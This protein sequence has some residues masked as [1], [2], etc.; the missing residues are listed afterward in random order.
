MTKGTKTTEGTEFAESFC[1]KDG[2]GRIGEG[3]AFFVETLQD[4]HV[5]VVLIVLQGVKVRRFKPDVALN[6][7]GKVRAFHEGEAGR[8]AWNHDARHVRADFIDDFESFFHLL[9]RGLIDEAEGEAF[10]IVVAV[11]E[12]VQFCIRDDA[13]RDVDESSF[14]RSEADAAQS[15]LFDG[16][17]RIADFNPVTYF[18]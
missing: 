2:G 9:R 18:K 7:Q 6:F 8:L 17:F 1:Q 15:D 10:T 13:V 16:A 14:E 12:I 4:S 5:D 3:E 11:A